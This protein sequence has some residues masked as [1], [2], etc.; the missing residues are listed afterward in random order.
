MA[1]TLVL[2]LAGPLQSWGTDSR[3]ENRR[4]EKLP[5][6]SAVVGLLTA[7]LGRS[8]DADVSDLASLKYGVRIDQPGTVIT[9]FHTAHSSKS[10]YIT[11]RDYLSDAKFVVAVEGEDEKLMDELAEAVK[12]PAFPLFLGRRSCPPDLPLSMGLQNEDLESSLKNAEWQGKKADEPEQYNLYLDGDFGYPARR[13]QDQPITFDY[14]HR[15]YG[16][17]LQSQKRVMNNDYQKS[18]KKNEST[19]HDP[20]SILEEF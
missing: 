4:T 10:S 8:R 9:D 13:I 6:K 3:F 20:F 12:K 14:H 18:L 1:K 7:A 15:Q 5:T 2:R 19:E 17:R 16:S 11:N